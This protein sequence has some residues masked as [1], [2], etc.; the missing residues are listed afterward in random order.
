MDRGAWQATVHRVAKSW[1]QLSNWEHTHR[2][3]LS[4]ITECL[5]W[6][7]DVLCQN[8]IK[9]IETNLT[10]EVK[11]LYIES[12]KILIKETKH[13]S[14]KW[15]DTPCSWIRRIN[16]VKMTVPLKAIYRF[17]VIPIKLPMTFLTDLEQV[18]LKCIWNHKIS[19]L[20][21]VILR[22]KD[23]AGIMYYIIAFTC[24]I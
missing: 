3:P 14:K 22:K 16:T 6:K 15:K 11:D 7:S 23:K 19:R 13:D 21:K 5:L 10:K 12:Y 9:Y 1:A 2:P 8:K 4:E 18:I 17:N 20:A 24:G